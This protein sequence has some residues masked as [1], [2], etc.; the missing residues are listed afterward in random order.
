MC[1]NSLWFGCLLE[2]LFPQCMQAVIPL[3]GVCWCMAYVCFQGMEAMGR[4]CSQ[5]L[6]AVPVTVRRTYGEVG[7]RLLL[8]EGHWEVALTLREGAQSL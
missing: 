5:C 7:C 1:E 4:A 8:V 6:S 2:A 3:I